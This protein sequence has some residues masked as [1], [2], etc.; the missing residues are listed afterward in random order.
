MTALGY[1]G[2]SFN[3][4]TGEEPMQAAFVFF[5]PRADRLQKVGEG[6]GGSQT[7]IAIA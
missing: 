3:Q 4:L 6:V 1:L 2:L 5:C 7:N